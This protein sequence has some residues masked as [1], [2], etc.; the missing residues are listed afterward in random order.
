MHSV[1]HGDDVID[2]GFRQD[3]VTKIENMARS[4]SGAAENFRYS[5]FDFFRRCE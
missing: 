1:D 2:R 4:T 3:A 5:T